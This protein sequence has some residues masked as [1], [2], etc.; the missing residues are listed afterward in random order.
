MD[1]GSS[2]ERLIRLVQETGERVVVSFDPHKDPVVLLPLSSYER[3]ASGGGRVE[4]VHSAPVLPLSEVRSPESLPNTPAPTVAGGASG[5]FSSEGSESPRT[6]FVLPEDTA[7]DPVDAWD[8]EEG[9]A[10]EYDAERIF[11]S[12]A[13]GAGTGRGVEGGLRPVNTVP[14]R[15]DAFP[16]SDRLKASVSRASEALQTMPS[17]PWQEG[18]GGQRLPIRGD[19]L[20]GEERFSLGMG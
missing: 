9:G 20:R 12:A 16:T 4:G 5:P 1:A 10:E 15:L 13:L 6:P 17:S 2:F 14:D 8:G 7:L 18:S 11:A 3:L 19:A